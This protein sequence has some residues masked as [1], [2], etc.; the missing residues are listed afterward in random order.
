MAMAFAP[1]VIKTNEI[2]IEEP[3]VVT[4]S[5]PLFWKDLAALG[6]TISSI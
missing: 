1:L 3:N 2:L 4:K 5:Y 6:F